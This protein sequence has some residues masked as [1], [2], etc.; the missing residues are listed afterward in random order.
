VHCCKFSLRGG[1]NQLNTV[2]Q[3]NRPIKTDSERVGNRG[4]GSEDFFPRWAVRI[5][6]SAIVDVVGNFHHGGCDTVCLL[7]LTLNNFHDPSQSLRDGCEFRRGVHSGAS[8]RNRL[9]GRSYRRTYSTC[10]RDLR[11][12]GDS[13]CPVTCLCPPRPW[14]GKV[15]RL[16]GGLNG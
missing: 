9:G 5:D 11:F 7:L 1:G 10:R 3:H 4:G 12:D 15:K 8:P 2:P 6:V 16:P 14:D 13:S